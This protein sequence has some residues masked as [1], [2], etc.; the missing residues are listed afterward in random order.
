MATIFCLTFLSLL[1]QFTKFADVPFVL[2]TMLGQM[3]QRHLPCVLFRSIRYASKFGA[4]VAKYTQTWMETLVTGMNKRSILNQDQFIAGAGL[5]WFGLFK[6]QP[7]DQ[8]G[9]FAANL[10]PG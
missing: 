2:T 3:T 5:T 4:P 1:L 7:S 10:E 8:V 6:I 9:G